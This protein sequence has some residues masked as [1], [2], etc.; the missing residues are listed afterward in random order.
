MSTSRSNQSPAA[1][2]FVAAVRLFEKRHGKKIKDL[3][4]LDEKS[5][6]PVYEAIAKEFFTQPDIHHYLARK[7]DTIVFLQDKPSDSC[8][9]PEEFDI[10][11]LRSDLFLFRED[12]DNSYFYLAGARVT[13][14]PAIDGIGD[15]SDFFSRLQKRYNNQDLRITS[16]IDIYRIRNYLNTHAYTR[17]SHYREVKG[18]EKLK[19]ILTP[20]WKDEHATV[21]VH[22]LEPQSGRVL[23]SVFINSWH[24]E[25]YSD[26]ISSR[27]NLTSE[28]IEYSVVDRSVYHPLVPEITERVLPFI[29]ASH[30]LQVAN[31]DANCALYGYN[32]L[33]ATARMLSDPDL[34]AKIY[35][36]AELTDQMDDA[37][38][39]ADAQKALQNFF[40]ENL[41]GYLPCYYHDRNIKPFSDLKKFHLAQRWNFSNELL[42]KAYPVPFA[43]K[44]LI[45]EPQRLQTWEPTF[46][47]E[48]KISSLHYTGKHKVIQYVFD[49]VISIIEKERIR[50][51]EKYPTV[52]D[53]NKHSVIVHKGKKRTVHPEEKAERVAIL[54]KLLEQAYE[55]LVVFENNPEANAAVLK[56]NLETMITTELNTKKLD[57]YPG[58]GMKLA[59]VLLNALSILSLFILPAKKFITGDWFF[60]LEGKTQ[61]AGE[62]A[63]KKMDGLPSIGVETTEIKIS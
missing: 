29:D 63:L 26:Y 53:Y 48:G 47:S 13:E 40:R 46:A 55:E 57:K 44:E 17:Q 18:Y 16:N 8:L 2:Q 52:I 35:A 12:A 7:S 42:S 23:A 21:M 10:Y 27:F 25:E 38:A 51:L 54:D 22:L 14:R 59:L 31:G 36:L 61:E 60:S 1:R 62:I 5:N 28:I 4:A 20:N 6:K 3:L 43:S 50:L 45:L 34:S 11:S 30:D 9:T 15:A 58:W 41:K 39:K 32:F 56:K 19:F 49:N 24:S 33:E 37:N